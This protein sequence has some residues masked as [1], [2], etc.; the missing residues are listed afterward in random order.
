MGG[1]ETEN[2]TVA[3]E[4]TPLVYTQQD[5][6]DALNL[7]GRMTRRRWAFILIVCAILFAALCFVTDDWGER[8]GT[9]IAA[10]AGGLVF[11]GI[12]RFVYYPWLAHRQFT[13]QP[14]AKLPQ[15]VSLASDGIV[16]VSERGSMRFLW[17]DFIGWDADDRVVILK[18]SPRIFMIVPTRIAADGFS[19][20]EMKRALEAS[21]GLAK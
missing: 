8:F 13:R 18:K 14:L 12:G 21:F 6:L 4:G 7:H 17:S 5:F 11:Y 9:T 16:F 10:A 2:G 19:L 15:R 1:H 3:A 20:D